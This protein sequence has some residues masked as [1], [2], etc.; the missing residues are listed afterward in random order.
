MKNKIPPPITKYL[1]FLAL[2]PILLIACNNGN[3]LNPIIWAE[4]F[5]SNRAISITG[6]EVIDVKAGETP[7]DTYT[8]TYRNGNSAELS[9]EEV[10]ADLDTNKSGVQNIKISRDGASLDVT[11]FVYDFGQKEITTEMAKRITEELTS[12]NP[13]LTAL[14]FVQGYNILIEQE[15]LNEGPVYIQNEQTVNIPGNGPVTF[16]PVW[17]NNLFR[18]PADFRLLKLAGEEGNP[19]DSIFAIEA[20]NIIVEYINGEL[21]GLNSSVSNNVIN[22]IKITGTDVILRDA[23]LYLSSSITPPENRTLVAL[24]ID[25]EGVLIEDVGLHGFETGVLISENASGTIRNVDFSGP[26]IINTENKLPEI[27]LTGC[28]ATMYDGATADVV[29]RCPEGLKTDAENWISSQQ[30]ANPGLIFGIEI[31]QDVGIGGAEIEDWEE[32]IIDGGKVTMD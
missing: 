23:E 6:P 1:I 24:N 9:A 11:V 32:V 19:V 26:C 28:T 20:N 25:A 14:K 27:N 30:V 12:G 17:G 13:D 21:S 7:T 18:G 10:F 31:L 22:G 3:S 2:I 16:T 29:I 15:G 4:Y 5:N 8:I